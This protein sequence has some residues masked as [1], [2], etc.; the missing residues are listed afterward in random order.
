MPKAI[1]TFIH[2]GMTVEILPYEKDIDHLNPRL[3]D[4]FCVIVADHPKYDIGDTE[5]GYREENGYEWGPDSLQEIHADIVKTHPGCIIRPLFLMDHGLVGVSLKDYRDKWDSGQVGWVFVSRQMIRDNWGIKRVT[6]EYIERAEALM[7]SE[8]EEYSRWLE[9][10]VYTFKVTNPAT[11]ESEKGDPMIGMHSTQLEACM[12][13]R[14]MYLSGVNLEGAANYTK[15]V[16]DGKPTWHLSPFYT[17]A[18][19]RAEQWEAECEGVRAQVCDKLHHRAQVT[20]DGIDFDEHGHS[21]FVNL[22]GTNEHTLK[23]VLKELSEMGFCTG[24]F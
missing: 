6:K 15:E 16:V 4:C 21:M 19:E 17:V 23:F 1:D 20:C 13:A 9:G 2:D 14:S 18:D 11:G 10:C 7:A 8:V 24:L 12:E 5:H 3:D 22:S